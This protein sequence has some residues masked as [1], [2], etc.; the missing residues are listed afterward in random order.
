MKNRDAAVL[1]GLLLLWALATAKEKPK[2]EQ[3]QGGIP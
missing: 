3:Y 1:I 2:E